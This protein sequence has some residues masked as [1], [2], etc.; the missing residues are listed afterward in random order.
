[1][2]YGWPPRRRRDAS[3]SIDA[4]LRHRVRETVDAGMGKIPNY[5]K[6]AQKGT[7]EPRR[8]IIDK[9]KEYDKDN[10]PAKRAA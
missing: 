5:F 7:P 10:I 6:S 9:M 3:T 1:M 4:F 8:Q 2:A